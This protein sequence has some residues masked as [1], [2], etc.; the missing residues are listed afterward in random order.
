MHIFPQYKAIYVHVC[1]S[2]L[3]A[4]HSETELANNIIFTSVVFWAS[5][6]QNGTPSSYKCAIFKPVAHEEPEI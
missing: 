4:K 6:L 5:E 2:R 1:T 3:I